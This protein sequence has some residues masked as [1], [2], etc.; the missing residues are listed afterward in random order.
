M[1]VSWT[2]SFSAIA[3]SALPEAYALK[4]ARRHI[5][6]KS[7]PQYFQASHDN[8]TARMVAGLEAITATVARL[9]EFASANPDALLVFTADHETGGLA[10]SGN[11]S[12]DAVGTLWSSAD[13]AGSVVPIL[14][15]GP[16]AHRFGGIHSNQEI[17]RILLS[18]TSQNPA[19]P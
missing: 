17:G 18:L 19:T 9:R 11:R 6:L 8:D 16:G 7:C 2:T 3:E 15:T 10:L 14:T 5:V 4:S 13:H 12:N 1:A